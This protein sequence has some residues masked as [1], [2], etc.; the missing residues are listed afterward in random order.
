MT[1]ILSSVTLNAQ[2]KI[3]INKLPYATVDMAI[4]ACPTT[5]KSFNAPSVLKL[6]ARL[7]L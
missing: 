4:L 7:V 1:N 3:L 2:Y 6:S 5:K